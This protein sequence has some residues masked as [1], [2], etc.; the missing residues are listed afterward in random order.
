LM[1]LLGP[2]LELSALIWIPEEGEI[3]DF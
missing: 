3:V 1:K 2:K